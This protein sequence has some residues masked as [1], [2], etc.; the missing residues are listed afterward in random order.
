MNQFFFFLKKFVPS[1]LLFFYMPSYQYGG[2]LF[3]FGIIFLVAAMFIWWRDI[4]RES[5]YQ[6][7]HTK[8]CK[9]LGFIWGY[10]RLE[11]I[12]EMFA[13]IYL[14]KLNYYGFKTRAMQFNYI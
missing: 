3:T 12:E 1:L 4:I 14:N 7:H 13:N 5:T 10:R 11:C 6:G 9:L 8:Q 2:Y